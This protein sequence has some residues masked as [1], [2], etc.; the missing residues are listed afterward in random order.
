MAYIGQS[1]KVKRTR[2][3]PQSAAP[4]NPT[5]G[6]VFYSDGTALAEGMYVYKNGSW[7]EIGAAAG[8]INYI[9]NNSAESGTTDWSTYDDGA[10]SIPVDG[11]AGS[12]STLTFSQNTSSPLRGTADFDLAKS[13]ADGQG[14]GVSYDFTIDNADQA[15]MLQISFDYVTSSAY[16]DDDMGIYIYDVTN[17]KLLRFNGEELKA[18]TQG[19]YSGYFQSAADS[20]SYR[21]I[22]HVK[23]TNASAYSL[24]FDNVRVGPVEKGNVGTFVSDFIEF[25]PTW[26]G[27]TSDPTTDFNEEKAYYRRVGDT[28]ELYYMANDRGGGEANGSGNAYLELPAQIQPDTDKMLT[29]NNPAFHAY[30]VGAGSYLRGSLSV[31]GNTQFLEDSGTFGITITGFTENTASVEILQASNFSTLNRLTLM[32]KF[33]VKGWESGISPTAPLPSGRSIIV[34]GA[35]NGGGSVTALT[36]NITFQEVTD[37][38]NSWSGSI[39]TAPETGWYDFSGSLSANANINSWFVYLYED[40]AQVRAIGYGDAQSSNPFSGKYYCIAGSEYSIRSSDSFT[41]SSS[42]VQHHISIVKLQDNT[43]IVLPQEKVRLLVNKDNAQTY[44]NTSPTVLWNNTEVDSHAGYNSGT[45]VYTCPKSGYYR[46][47][48][49]IRSTNASKTF[50]DDWIVQL[51]VDGTII[52]GAWH[53]RSVSS[54]SL[55]QAATLAVDNIYIEKGQSVSIRVFFTGSLPIRESGGTIYNYWSLT[56]DD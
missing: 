45:G 20:T 6:D 54:S 10:S 29:D 31:Y 5:E 48:S 2:F 46:I 53:E 43:D 50:G 34:E 19:H 35:D 55:G 12:P 1:P 7:Q 49:H 42:T 23:S 18:S 33:P 13:A 26:R 14:E 17:S 27:V 37:N 47:C 56:S 16:A 22:L 44:N 32:A 38:T 4:S 8:G 9:E 36:T 39:F 51:D 52:K 24:N 3:T 21:L 30:D 25:T 40:G 41:L 11:T 28:C 15:T